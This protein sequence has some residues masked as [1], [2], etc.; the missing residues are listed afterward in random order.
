MYTITHIE[1]SSIRNF[2]ERKDEA[3]EILRLKIASHFTQTDGW[4]GLIQW[5]HDNDYLV[6]FDYDDSDEENG[7]QAEY[8]YW[9]FELRK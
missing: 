2:V 4:K 9:R 6:F 3:T 7:K 8:E 5:K 1:Y